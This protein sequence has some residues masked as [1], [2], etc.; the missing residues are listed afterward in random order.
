MNYACVF[1]SRFRLRPNPKY[2]LKSCKRQ[3][4]LRGTM[5]EGKKADSILLFQNYTVETT[6]NVTAELHKCL[7]SQMCKLTMQ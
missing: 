2:S 5:K 3:V 7:M 6:F 1:C 4:F